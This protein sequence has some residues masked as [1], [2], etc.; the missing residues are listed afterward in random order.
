MVLQTAAAI[1]L[2][3]VDRPQPIDE[4]L[5]ELH[6]A[7]VGILDTVLVEPI[8]SCPEC[9]NADHVWRP[10]LHPPGVFLQLI[11]IGRAHARTSRARLPKLDM[12]ADAHSADSGRAHERLVTR[13]GEDIDIHRLHV[14]R[15]YAGSL[16]R[17]DSNEDFVTVV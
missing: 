10:E 2:H 6:L 7:G 1:E 13:K 5:R 11:R 17:I 9:G 8:L 3:A 15:D 16:G 14:D 4:P 12:L